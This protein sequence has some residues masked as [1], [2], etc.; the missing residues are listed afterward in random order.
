MIWSDMNGQ[1]ELRLIEGLPAGTDE[2][3]QEPS[4]R[5]LHEL[6]ASGL[7]IVPSPLPPWNL[8]IRPARDHRR[9]L[10]LRPQQAAASA[11]LV[12]ASAFRQTLP[13]RFATPS[14]FQKTIRVLPL[15][16]ELL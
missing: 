14:T 2:R 9:L 5:P 4:F 1:I 10:L 12:P 16:I 15:Q 3:L 8:P 6:R 11:A 13:V 7:R